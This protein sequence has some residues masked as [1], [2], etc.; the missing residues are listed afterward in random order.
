VTNERTVTAL[1]CEMPDGRVVSMDSAEY[2]EWQR[3]EVAKAPPFSVEQKARLRVLLK[4]MARRLRER[5]IAKLAADGEQQAAKE[6][7][8]RLEATE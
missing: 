3:A 4:P 5:A 7:A 2:L 1:C 8:F 6:A